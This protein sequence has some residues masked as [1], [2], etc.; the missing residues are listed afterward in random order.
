[1]EHEEK[2]LDVL[3]EN[4]YRLK[5]KLV[6]VTCMVILESKTHVPDFMTRARTLRG[7]AIVS[8]DDKVQRKPGDVAY[9]GL[10]V[11]FLPETEEIYANIQNLVEQLK[12]LPGTI[13]IKVLEYNNRKILKDGKPIIF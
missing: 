8:Q 5:F 6:K 12:S 1:M 3:V 10:N 13:N 9:L 7:V 2:N 11:K 4:A